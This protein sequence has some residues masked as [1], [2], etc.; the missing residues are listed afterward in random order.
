M[1]TTYTQRGRERA[2]ERQRSSRLA[3]I[4]IDSAYTRRILAVSRLANSYSSRTLL[5]PRSLSLSRAQLYILDLAEK[6][7]SETERIAAAA[8]VAR[9][10]EFSP[11][12][13][14]I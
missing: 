12:R 14:A 7:S 1:H 6:T 4:E 5:S 3:S 8:S 11:A 13:A 9:H 2:R 10:S